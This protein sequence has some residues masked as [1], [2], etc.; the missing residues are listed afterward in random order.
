MRG[1]LEK[2]K[3]IDLTLAITCVLLCLI[4]LVLMYSTSLNGNRSIF[5]R[6]LINASGAIVLFLSFAF[7]D[8]R[9]LARNSRYLYVGAVLLL[10]GVLF[11][12]PLTKG[13]HR[14]FD[15][16][17]FNFQPAEFTKIVMILVLARFF[18]VHRGAIN[19]WKNIILSFIYTFIPIF[20]IAREPDL[21]SSIVVFTIWAG[22]LLVSRVDKK[23]F[24]Y[25]FLIFALFSGVAWKYVLHDY[26]RHRIETFLDPNLDPQ[27]KGYNVRQAIIAVGS[28]KVFGTGLGKGLQSQLRFLPERQTDFVFASA[29][30]E[31]G[32]LGTTVILVLYA[33]LLYRLLVIYR[34]SRDDLSRFIIAGIFFMLFSQI[35]I[36]I[37]MNI[38]IMPVTGIP[39]PML[40]YGGSSLFTVAICMGI[41]EA[42]AI[43]A[44]SSHLF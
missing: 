6:Q 2:F 42:V 13:S 17:L 34:L 29:A 38:G 11:F 10:I 35:V 4:G 20:L 44:K 32:F 3:Y 37:G 22:I 7:F 18:A 15:L 28:G 36:N 31:L 1:F 21:G 43:R 26:Q 41:A 8:F 9:V 40:S 12:S 16:G 19:S 14:W 23:V 33:I 5:V 39:L 24:L 27:N 25:L 30:E